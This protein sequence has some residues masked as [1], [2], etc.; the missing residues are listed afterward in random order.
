MD[1]RNSLFWRARERAVDWLKRNVGIQK[2][3]L[4]GSKDM[5]KERVRLILSTP[6]RDNYPVLL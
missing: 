6:T 5:K 1:H 3:V 4:F 2:Q